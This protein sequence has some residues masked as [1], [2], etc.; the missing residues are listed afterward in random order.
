VAT[1][2]VQ[3]TMTVLSLILRLIQSLLSLSRTFTEFYL[4]VIDC[5]FVIGCALEIQAGVRGLLAL[6]ET[7]LEHDARDRCTF[8]AR[9]C[10]FLY[11]FSLST[12]ATCIAARPDTP[13]VYWQLVSGTKHSSPECMTYGR[14]S[15][16]SGDP[17]E[18]HRKPCE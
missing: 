1:N 4:I 3:L 13:K 11:S 7:S 9:Q 14:H 10:F 17:D 16:L 8:A 18:A 2:P 6:V 5:A 15:G 12:S